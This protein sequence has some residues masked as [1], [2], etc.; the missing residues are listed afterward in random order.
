MLLF[1]NNESDLRDFRKNENQSNVKYIV[2]SNEELDIP[3]KKILQIGKFFIPTL[4]LFKYINQEIKKTQYEEEYNKTISG[5]DR[6]YPLMLA[7][8]TSKK[9]MLVFVCSDTEKD[10]LYLK[11]LRDFIINNLGISKSACK[12]YKQFLKDGIEPIPKKELSNIISDI[13]TVRRKAE[14]Y[15]RM[16]E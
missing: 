10:Y 7:L 4:E 1:I 5:Y 2:V 14:E 6:L 13:D 3:K 12:S 15:A 8:I 16:T 9:E 11:F